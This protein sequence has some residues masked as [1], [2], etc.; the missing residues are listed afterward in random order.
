MIERAL[1][2]EKLLEHTK[3]LMTVC[4]GSHH[5]RSSLGEKNYMDPLRFI[6]NLPVNILILTFIM[7]LIFVRNKKKFIKFNLNWNE[8]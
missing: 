8:S 1:Y 2:I 7:S 3:K 4:L 5:T 6:P